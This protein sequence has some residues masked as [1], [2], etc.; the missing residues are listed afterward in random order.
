MNRLIAGMLICSAST[1]AYDK[2]FDKRVAPILIRRCLG[3]HNDELKDGDIS[4]EDRDSLLKGGKRGP[5]IVP[6]NR[7]TAF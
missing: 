1:S 4:F 5:A 6:A 3:C 2:F 7:K